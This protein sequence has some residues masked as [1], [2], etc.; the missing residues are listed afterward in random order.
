MLGGSGQGW[1]GP[2]SS[3]GRSASASL[4][5]VFALKSPNQFGQVFV[6]YDPVED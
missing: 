6:S 5:C 2:V 1:F 4:V 3:E